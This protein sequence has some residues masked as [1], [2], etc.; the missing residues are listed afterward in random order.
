MAE[1]TSSGQI[2][3][4]AYCRERVMQAHGKVAF[5]RW[6]ELPSE[7]RKAWDAAAVA[8]QLYRERERS[9]KRA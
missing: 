6:R 4:E 5:L 7:V 3:Y 9:E 8:I 2:G 1:Q